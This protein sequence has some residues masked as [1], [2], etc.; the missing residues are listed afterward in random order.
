MLARVLEP[1]VMDTPEEARDYDAMDHAEVNRRFVDDLLPHLAGARRPLAGFGENDS[2][3]LLDLGTGT[4]LIPIELCRCAENLSIVA[5]D[6]AHHM[7]ELAQR[8]IDARGLNHRI[9]V[10]WA[11]AKSLPFCDG[12]FDGVISN[13]IVHHLPDPMVA[14]REAVRVTNAGILLFRDLL[15]PSGENEL[16]ALVNRYAPAAGRS[17][18]TD[19][20]RKMFADSLRAALTLDEIRGLVDELGFPPAGVDQTSDQHWTWIANRSTSSLS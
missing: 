7:L 6:A 2:L 9:T 4:A 14:L 20:Q 16:R 3:R 8:N 15:R 12:H 18:E 5:V 11:D 10:Q 17:N 19:H 1:E 13:S